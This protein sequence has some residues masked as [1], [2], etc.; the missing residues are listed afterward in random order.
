[1]SVPYELV[2]LSCKAQPALAERFFVPEFQGELPFLVAA[3]APRKLAALSEEQ[4]LHGLLTS[5]AERDQNGALVPRAEDRETLVMLLE[6]LRQGYTFASFE[7]LVL[8]TSGLL[9][10]KYGVQPS[11]A[12]LCTGRLLAP[13][14]AQIRA[15]LMLDLW[16]ASAEIADNGLAV[17]YRR[18][19]PDLFEGLDR[20]AL[21]APTLEVCVYINMVTR[22]LRDDFVE[23]GALEAFLVDEVID[24]IR[25]PRLK[26]KVQALATA[27]RDD[28]RLDFADLFVA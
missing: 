19:I 11:Q 6:I 20:A 8:E 7:E 21:H 26:E 12:A 17:E 3:D 4:L 18:L 14:S 9:R 28:Q 16:A 13:D 25:E 22:Y 15:D 5:F 1:M 2:W 10:S 23:T 27:A 24:V